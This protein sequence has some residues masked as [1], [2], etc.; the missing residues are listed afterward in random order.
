MEGGCVLKVTYGHSWGRRCERTGRVQYHLSTDRRG[1]STDGSPRQ[2]N[3]DLDIDSSSPPGLAHYR[4]S[5]CRVEMA[6]PDLP[7]QGGLF[8]PTIGEARLQ[9]SRA[10]NNQERS[11]GKKKCAPRQQREMR[12][13]RTSLCK[14]ESDAWYYGNPKQ[15]SP[16]VPS[17]PSMYQTLLWSIPS[18]RNSRSDLLN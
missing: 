8:W 2:L 13:R 5:S 10:P 17:P 15:L 14:G 11:E 7:F 18:I 3:E 1:G 16:F 6:A 12:L 9:G 4:A